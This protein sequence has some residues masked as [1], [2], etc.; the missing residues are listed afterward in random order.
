MKFIRIILCN[1]LFLSITSLHGQQDDEF[2][3]NISLTN[4]LLTVSKFLNNGKFHLN[5]EDGVDYNFYDLKSFENSGQFQFN[6]N[7]SIIIVYNFVI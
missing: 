5:L 6:N 3:N 4:K 1:L 7:L 2:V